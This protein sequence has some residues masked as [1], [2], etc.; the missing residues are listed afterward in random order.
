MVGPAGV[1]LAVGTAFVA[2]VGGTY[3]S[4]RRDVGRRKEDIMSKDFFTKEDRV[5]ATDYCSRVARQ[6]ITNQRGDQISA[7]MILEA[8]ACTELLQD[9]EWLNHGVTQSVART[10]A[11]VRILLSAG[12]PPD[13]IQAACGPAPDKGTVANACAR[14]DRSGFFKMSEDQDFPRRALIE[15]AEQAAVG[16]GASPKFGIVSICKGSENRNGPA[17][18]IE[19]GCKIMNKNGFFKQDFAPLELPPGIWDLFTK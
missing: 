2:G 16:S 11:D 7:D 8:E 1:I 12:I 9:G 19:E 13:I 10:N 6:Y 4:L 18:V 3:Y 14:L 17:T 15:L 5:N